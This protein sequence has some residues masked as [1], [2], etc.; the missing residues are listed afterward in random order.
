MTKVLF[1]CMGNI[2]RSPMAEG[3]FAKALDNYD[4]DI[5]ASFTLASAGTIGYHVGNPPD[6]RAIEVAKRRGIDI[7]AQRSRKV[8]ATDFDTFDYIMAMDKEN[9]SDLISSSP[10][11]SKAEIALF[12][13]Y[14]K[15]ASTQEVPDPYYGG[16][17]GFDHCLDLIEDAAEGLLEHLLNKA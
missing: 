17:A 2:C 1:V 3:A 16:D 9:L 12:L 7:S 5:S 14:A 10:T 13:D 4:S 15:G 8:S 6:P 11:H